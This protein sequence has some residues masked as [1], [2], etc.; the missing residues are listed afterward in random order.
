MTEP[1]L[2]RGQT[3]EGFFADRLRQKDEIEVAWQSAEWWEREGLKD[4]LAQ[5]RL[6]LDCAERH[7]G[8]RHDYV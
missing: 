4:D 3:W 7:M 6:D 1:T 5:L 8:V 2:P